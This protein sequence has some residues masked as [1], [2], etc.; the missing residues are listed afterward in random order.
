M[1]A[2]RWLEEH[3]VPVDHTGEVYAGPVEAIA[4][5]PVS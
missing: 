4:G 2:E 3:G 1:D 5:V